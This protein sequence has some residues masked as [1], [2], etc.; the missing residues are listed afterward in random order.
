MLLVEASHLCF[1]SFVE[2]A[3][4]CR[5]R[6]PS[7]ASGVRDAGPSLCSLPDDIYGLIFGELK[8]EDNLEDLESLSLTCKALHS[9]LARYPAEIRLDL[10]R[11]VDQ[12]QLAGIITLLD[13]DMTA[14]LSRARSIVSQT[15]VS[16][17]F[18]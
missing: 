9:A 15:I 16:H 10:R 6:A 11:G 1:L 12:N 13:A 7:A 17:A 8:F 14:A 5:A 2:E 3:Y 18:A 4:C